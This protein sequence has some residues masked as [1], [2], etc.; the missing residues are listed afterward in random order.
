M[1]LSSG[2]PPRQLSE[3]APA[4]L[5]QFQARVNSWLKS[6]HCVEAARPTH[7]KKCSAPSRNESGGIRLQGHGERRRDPLGPPSPGAEASSV[8]AT[9]RRYRCT[10]CGGTQDV[11]P[12]GLGRRC[13]YSL[14]AI[15]SALF[16]WAFERV[17][18]NQVRDEISPHLFIGLNRSQ[19]WRS[20]LRWTRAAPTLFGADSTTA[21]TLRDRA[22]RIAR[23]I[24]ATRPPGGSE[25]ERIFF[26]AQVF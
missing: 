21:T 22:S 14:P 4:T 25:R 18:A 17:P 8:R 15:A 26:A 5:I 6:N 23:W 12:P 1:T 20:L 7:C 11:S 13:R 9:V 2:A 24:R 19:R 16:L 3:E 10:A